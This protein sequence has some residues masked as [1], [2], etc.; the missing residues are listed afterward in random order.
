MVVLNGTDH[1]ILLNESYNTF[2]DK[3]DDSLRLVK[4]L[5]NIPTGCVIIAAVKDDASKNLKPAARKIF[6][7]M[8]SQ[9]IK[10]LGFKS[11]WGFIGIKGLK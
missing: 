8:G 1:K 2:T 4:D 11:A 5:E 3:R 9:A 10:Q 6:S 7:D